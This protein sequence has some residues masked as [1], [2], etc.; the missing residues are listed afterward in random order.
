LRKSKIKNSVLYYIGHAF[1]IEYFA[2]FVNEKRNIL[3]KKQRRCKM[4]IYT[5]IKKT[6]KQKGIS[7]TKLEADL[8]FAR[9]T[10]YKWDT[11]QPGIG[12][13]KKVSDYLGVTMEYLLSD[14]KES[15]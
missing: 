3:R 12:K 9:S 15:A 14:Q 8:G 13:L 6:C 11:H 5:N 4:P 1:N 2:Q 7:V 10:I